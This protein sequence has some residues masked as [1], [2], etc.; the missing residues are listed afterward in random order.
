[1]RATA[2]QVAAD[3]NRGPSRRSMPTRPKVIGTQASRGDVVV[4]GHGG[5]PEQRPGAGTGGEGRRTLRDAQRDDRGGEVQPQRE[6]VG[7]RQ[8]DVGREAD[9]GEGQEPAVGGVGPLG[10]VKSPDQAPRREQHQRQRDR[11]DDGIGHDEIAAEL[12]DRRRQ[13]RI[14]RG[15]V[16]LGLAG[17]ARQVGGIGP[18]SR[19]APAAEEV[20][21]GDD[22][23]D[24]VGEEVVEQRAVA[25]SEAEDQ[26]QERDRHPGP[27]PP[28]GR[29]CSLDHGKAMRSSSVA[30][31]G[32]SRSRSIRGSTRRKAMR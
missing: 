15:P 1:M 9:R 28:P 19:N 4:A 24:L 14:P 6:E 7:R 32:W 20:P 17:Y 12:R 27:P 10:R 8:V 25:Q 2:T 29:A 23:P 22:L 21:R 3:R 30:K 18:A 31:R 26:Q 5:Q 13:H 11:V 16:G